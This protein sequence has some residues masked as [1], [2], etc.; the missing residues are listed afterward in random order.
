MPQIE[1]PSAL[2]D[3][4]ADF[5][6]NKIR[7]I[8]EQFCNESMQKTYHRDCTSFDAFWPLDREEILN[9]IKK[10]NPTTSI[11]DPCNMGFLLKFK[12]IIVDAITTITNQ[13]PS[14][15]E[16]LDDWKVAAVRPLIKD[17]NIR[18][19]FK[20]YRPISNLSFL[21][22][23]IE[24]AA[25]VQLQK[26]FDEHSLLP[27]H[28]SAYRQHHLTETTVLNM[29]DNI[30][31]NMETQ[32]YTSIVSLDLSA[33]FETVNHKI[34]LG[35]LKSY[36]G[37]SDHALACISSYLSKRKFLV[38]IG[39]QVSKTIELDYSVPQ[40]SIL[41]LIL[42]NC[43]AS[44]LMEIIPASEENFLSGYADDHAVI[45]SFSLNNKKIRQH[46]AGDIDRIRNWMEENQLK[47]NDAKTEFNII[48]TVSNLK[49]NTLEN[50]EIGDS[51]IHRTSKIKF[52]GVYL[53]ENLSLKDHVQNRA[54]KAHHNLR[55]IQNI[56]KYINIDTTKMLLST[57]VLSQLDYV[58]SILSMAP[59]TTIKPY[60][61]IQNSAARV[62]YKKSKRDDAH[63]CL[64]ELHWLPIKY[65]C[66]FK[67][68]TVVF[69]TLQGNAPQYLKE[70]LQQ[71]Q[72]P[73]LTRKSTSSGI[74]LDTPFN[75]RKSLADRGFSYAAAKYWNDLLDHIKTA[76]DI[77]KF[78]SLL[79]THF[80][81]LA[82]SLT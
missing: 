70:K 54:R 53:D 10:M 20:N 24:K 8:R 19:E 64:C 72:F 14:T 46:I 17:A 74:T 76:E 30:L 12:E 65:R 47:M 59:A 57:L 4:F 18:T 21:S 27:S 35:I 56:R 49:K 37:I 75:R 50:I 63:T 60:Q 23:I 62:A 15:G 68:L 61:K 7:K 38:Q 52:L 58:N 22:K 43:Y 41:G 36:F 40:G 13:S 77:N 78:K 26:Q 81:R 44:T 48:G 69:N 42:F 32:K 73:R 71:K 79:K 3:K 29:C 66:T 67:L 25:Q 45:H 51:L 34:L 80:F 9:I 2:P 55:L 28:Q 6:F 31:K 16:F 82:F 11:M 33:A 39:R 5:F 1:P